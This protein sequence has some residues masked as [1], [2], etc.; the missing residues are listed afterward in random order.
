[1]FKQII[2][3]ADMTG[4]TYL[5]VVLVLTAISILILIWG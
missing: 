1:M 5:A 2:G 3:E 4:P